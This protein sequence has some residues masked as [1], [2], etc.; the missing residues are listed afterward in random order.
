VRPGTTIRQL[1]GYRHAK[2]VL[3][4][5]DFESFARVWIAEFGQASSRILKLADGRVISIVRRPMSEGGLVST[6]EDIAERQKLNAPLE[7]KNQC[8]DAALKNRC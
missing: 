6:T 8:F 3:G 4:N 5:I 7:Q 2:G 1:L